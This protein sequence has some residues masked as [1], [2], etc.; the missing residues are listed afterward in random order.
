M[1]LKV[2]P[3]K[4]SI[5][6]DSNSITDVSVSIVIFSKFKLLILIDANVSVNDIADDLYQFRLSILSPSITSSV[7]KPYIITH[8]GVSV[9]SDISVTVRLCMVR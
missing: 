6:S 2:A 9:D 4:L 8:L 1:L 7:S 5:L 3:F